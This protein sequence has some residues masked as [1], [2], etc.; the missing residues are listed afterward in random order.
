MYPVAVAAFSQGTLSARLSSSWVGLVAARRVGGVLRFTPV[1]EAGV[2]GSPR[3]VEVVYEGVFRSLTQTA[4]DILRP[5]APREI[6]RVGTFFYTEPDGSAGEVT[7][8]GFPARHAEE[9]QHA[10][11]TW[12]ISAGI[13]MS[14]P[15][16]EESLPFGSAFV[17]RTTNPYFRLL[18]GTIGI[19]LA[20]WGLVVMVTRGERGEG[21]FGVV[22]SGWL[23]A[24]VVLVALMVVSG[25]LFVMGV[26]RWSWWTKARREARSRG[27]EL[28]DSLKFWN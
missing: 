2:A 27:V 24:I 18:A 1:D 13:G 19:G 23:F 25:A 5:L 28:P 15:D 7:A 26:R 22:S 6:G 16:P 17:N 9:I 4:L 12:E 20:A 14:E 21:P 11:R 3:V 8:E 10:V